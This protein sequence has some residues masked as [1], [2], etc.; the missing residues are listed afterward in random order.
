MLERSASWV[1][2]SIAGLVCTGVLALIPGVAR[3]D[4]LIYVNQAGAVA[5]ANADGSGARAV[6][7]S[8][9]W[10]WPSQSDG[11]TIAALAPS[12][13]VMQ[14]D[15]SGKLTGAVQTPAY[16]SGGFDVTLY[17]RI[18]PDGS[19]VA[20]ANL[21]PS[22]GVTVYWGPTNTNS[23]SH[24]SQSLGQEDMTAP[25]WIDSSAM[26]LTHFG[27]TVTDT[28]DQLYMY[29]AGNGDNTESGWGL[30]PYTPSLMNGGSWE[31][32]DFAA[33]INRQESAVAFAMDDQGD[34]GGTAQNAIIHVFPTTGSPPQLDTSRGCQLTLM[35]NG[36]DSI[37]DDGEI[38][39]S[40]SP[41]GTKF[42][43]ATDAG[44]WVAH[45]PS[46]WSDCSGLTS[47]LTIPGGTYPY[48]SPAGI[49][50]TLSVVKAGTGQG[51]VTSYPTGISCGQTCSHAYSE[52]AMVTL[53]AHPAAGS[54]FTGWS[55]DACSG[56]T[57]T[58]C[59]VTM[60]ADRTVRATFTKI[61]PP[62]T[63]ITR[64]VVNAT[65]GTAGVSFT[66]SGGVG[67]L[68]F[69]CRLDGAAYASCTSPKS[70]SH[71]AKGTH[72]FRVEAIDSR[73]MADPT[74][75]TYSFRVTG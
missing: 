4:S 33:A 51:S 18:S 48:W 39:P 21:D 58:T 27:E 25:S 75:A 17:P 50:S 9:N 65:R 41:D 16:A 44:V 2:R 47:H 62:N 71:L 10:K 61:P 3:A 19:K 45:L 56:G 11:G 74:P 31:A 66:G 69:R 68:R 12:G 28:Q 49:K 70:Y 8:T 6:N 29:T 43:Y 64:H 60:S 67:S 7:S 63:T 13:A 14:M 35:P 55:G 23:L 54:R 15:Q 26:L 20:Y 72:T 34:H 38:S 36:S 42:A 57:S 37:A 46:D 52:G 1:L 30:D 40:F 5:I 24:P 73:G 59:G 32:T 53:T 22:E